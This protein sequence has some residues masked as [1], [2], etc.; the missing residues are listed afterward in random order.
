M[1]GE[2]H[3]GRAYIY[4]DCYADKPQ[5]GYIDRSGALVIPGGKYGDMSSQFREGLTRV[6]IDRFGKKGCIDRYGKLIIPC[7]Y[8]T[9]TFFVE[10]LARGSMGNGGTQY[11]SNP[12]L[13]T[14]APS[15]G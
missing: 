5:G 7:Q 8:D 9:L 12:F 3:E 2:F 1:E 10:G 11:I 4:P 14:E 6:S 13:L 15:R